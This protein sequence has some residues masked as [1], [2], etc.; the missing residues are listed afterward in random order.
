ML[1]ASSQL[2][3][4]VKAALAGEDLILASE[5]D[6]AFKEAV[7]QQVAGLVQQLRCLLHDNQVILW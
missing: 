2:S 7:D 5:V 4:L 6:V 3:R 1:D